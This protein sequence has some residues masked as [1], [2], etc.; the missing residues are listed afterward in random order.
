MHRL[1]PAPDRASLEGCTLRDPSA[2]HP[3]AGAYGTP[4]GVPPWVPIAG[5]VPDLDLGESVQDY[6][7][8]PT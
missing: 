5:I 2:A 7:I 8:K 4:G 1:A 3:L 6:P